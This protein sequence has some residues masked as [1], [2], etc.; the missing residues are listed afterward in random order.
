MPKNNIHAVEHEHI[1]SFSR[2][3]AFGK[4][5]LTANWNFLEE[6]SPTIKDG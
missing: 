1:S 3:R 2:R 6:V 5:G 4:G